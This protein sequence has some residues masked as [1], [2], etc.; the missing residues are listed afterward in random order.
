MR[1]Q[2]DPVNWPIVG[3]PIFH[4]AFSFWWPGWACG[5][6]VCII[7]QG[8]KKGWALLRFCRDFYL[9]RSRAGWRSRAEHRA[10]IHHSHNEKFKYT[11]NNIPIFSIPSIPSILSYHYHQYHHRQQQPTNSTCLNWDIYQSAGLLNVECIIKWYFWYFAP[12]QQ[13]NYE[14]QCS[15]WSQ[16]IWLHIYQNIQHSLCLIIFQLSFISNSEEIR[17]ENIFSH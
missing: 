6:P 11:N 5:I 12:W 15:C 9:N 7:N 17:T 1:S 2:D 14:E 13:S 8:L 10:T 16:N 3:P 4:F